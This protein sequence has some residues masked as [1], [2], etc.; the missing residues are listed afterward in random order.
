MKIQILT[1]KNI[2][3]LIGLEQDARISEPEI[4]TEAFDT[5]KVRQTTSTALANPD[6]TSARCIMCIND[7]DR[8]V[9]R[10]D[11]AI[12]PSFSFGGNVQAYVDWV[13]VLK[14]YRH[15]GI[16]QF[17]FTQMGEYLKGLG[18][19]EYF[20]HMA[21]NSD[22]QRFYRSLSGAVIESCDVLRMRVM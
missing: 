5:D 21:N 15:K 6:F 1:T 3:L 2:D 10:I 11:F 18:I 9:G 7:T 20:L 14:E 13:Y 16:A 8:A 22:A 12:L 17:L 19:H 4:F